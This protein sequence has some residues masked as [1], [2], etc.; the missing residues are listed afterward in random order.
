[1]EKLQLSVIVPVYNSERYL[2]TLVDSI[3]AQTFKDFELILVDDGA[4]DSSPAI[5]DDYAKQDK[6][7]RVVHKENGGVSDARNRGIC[8][9]QGEY[10]FFSDNDDYLFPDYFEVL[11]REVG[12]RDFIISGHLQGMRDEFEAGN[13][14]GRIDK[15]HGRLCADDPNGIRYFIAAID[16]WIGAI[17]RCLF[18]RSVI[19]E[20]DCFFEMRNQEDVLFTERYMNCVDS[21]V[22]ID[23]QGYYY[24]HNRG[25]LG[26][27]HKYVGEYDVISRLEQS[28]D[29][30]ETR[31]GTSNE[32]W[33]RNHEIQLGIYMSSY[34]IKGYHA[35]TRVGMGERLRRWREIRRDK[36][37]RQMNPI[38]Q[39]GMRKR[40]LQCCRYG[41]Y[42]LVDP[43]LALYTRFKPLA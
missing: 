14:N 19:L 8:E 35:D 25:S 18:K 12:G 31:F 37:F 32:E 16:D 15:V 34:L 1:M 4:T 11:L 10:L 20:Y 29:S 40:I 33:K 24:L 22:K 13:L 38:L 41:L 17:W 43:L 28:W 39:R 3:L 23:Y 6:R 21:V 5:C 7:V 26:N 9:A 27:S 36:W 30:M 42:Y 2:K